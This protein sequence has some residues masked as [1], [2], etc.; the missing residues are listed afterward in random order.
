MEFI[1]FFIQ[2]IEPVIILLII[3]HTFGGIQYVTNYI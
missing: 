2:V 3:L 1:E